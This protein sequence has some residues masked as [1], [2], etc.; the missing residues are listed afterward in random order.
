[1]E[2]R[3]LPGPP[4]IMSKKPKRIVYAGA[5]SIK[6][7]AQ[8]VDVV[9]SHIQKIAHIG[10]YLISDLS[11]VGDFGLTGKQLKTLK[12]VLGVPVDHTDTIVEVAKRLKSI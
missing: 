12:K 1:M 3:V 2:V 5:R 11:Q 8:H 4:K 9:M 7:L 10:D 6:K